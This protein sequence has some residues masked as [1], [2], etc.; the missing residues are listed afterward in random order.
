MT[1]NLADL[2]PK[3]KDALKISEEALKASN[4]LYVITSGYRSESEQYALW[5]QGRKGL[6][7][8]NAARKIAGM[9]ALP[10]S[11][12]TYVVT[13][14]DGKTTKSN[15]QSGMA[16][17]VVPAVLENG[18]L[19]P[20][21]PPITDKRWKEISDIMKANGWSWGGDWKKFPDP[22]HYEIKE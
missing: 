14:C 18:K 10:A 4:V 5:C 20:I 17:D 19:Y 11:E 16:V 21:W 13:N 15:H 12:N 22:P 3:A 7:E 9:Y 6:E 8:V 2:K 1:V